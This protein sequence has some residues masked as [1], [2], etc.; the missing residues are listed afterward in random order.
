[1]KSRRL[2]KNTDCPFCGERVG[3]YNTD[4]DTEY[5]VTK[6]R[7]QQYF[8]RSCFHNYIEEQRKLREER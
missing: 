5:T 8:H 3:I 7:T 1:M 4:P 6:R 2:M